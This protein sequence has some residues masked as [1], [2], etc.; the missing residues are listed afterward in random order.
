LLA[1]HAEPT[2]S[3]VLHT[4]ARQNLPP[5]QSESAVQPA[6]CVPLHVRPVQSTTVGV[7]HDAPEPVQVS[8]NVDCAGLPGAQ[9]APRQDTVVA[10]NAS[11]GHTVLLPVHVSWTSHA[12]ALPRQT[13]ELGANASVGQAALA[14]VQFS[15]ASHTE[16]APRQ[17]VAPDAKASVGHVVLLPVHVS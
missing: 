17:R 12:P 15:A 16:I 10:A 4:P 1:W 11:L 9:L 8:A 2:V 3:F 7:G 13:V 6:H 5:A 14:P